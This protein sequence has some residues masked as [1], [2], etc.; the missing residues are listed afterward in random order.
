MTAATSVSADSFPAPPEP[1]LTADEIVARAERI[2][3]GLVER[4]HETEQRGYYALDTHKEFLAAGFYRLL[5]PRRYGGYEFGVDTH[6]RVV[7]A[8]AR[9][10]PSTAW[11]F[12]FGASHAHAVATLFGPE[13]QDEVFAGGDF[14]CPGTIGPVGFAERAEGGWIVDGVHRYSSGS[15]YATHFIGHS[16]VAGADGGPPAP[17]MFIVR[18][19]QWERLDDWGDQL[20]L[21]GSGSHSVKIDRAFVPEYRVLNTHIGTATVENGT[22]GLA[23]H[24]NTLY[25]GGVLSMIQFQNGALAIGMATGALDAYGELMR[26]RTTIYPPI[27]PRAEDPDFQFDYGEATARISTARAALFDAVRQWQETANRGSAEFT[28]EVDLR[29]SLISR[30]TVR[31]SWSAMSEN[32]FPTAGSSAV[33]TGERIERIWRD[34]STQQSHAGVSI[35]LAKVANRQLAELVFD[36]A[37]DR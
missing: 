17:M 30:E 20:G 14:I 13:A 35:F 16:L 25:G 10:C 29:L 5:V 12:T 3:A 1:R 22:P 32:L 24:G 7:T 15:P 26:D 23:L 31:L 28:R 36:V 9:G 2:A 19:D 18:R 27:R 33:R 11:M 8:L 4:Q 37:G 21:K 34:M 6:L